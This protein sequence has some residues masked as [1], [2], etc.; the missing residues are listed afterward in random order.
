MTPLSEGGIVCV[1]T[2]V[3]AFYDISSKSF[4]GS[5]PTV[6]KEQM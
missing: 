3:I 4:G 2:T 5:V 1:L 6:E